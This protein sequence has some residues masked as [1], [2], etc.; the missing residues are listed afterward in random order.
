MEY[1]V[2]KGTRYFGT[3]NK[4]LADGLR[5]NGFRQ[6]TRVW[7]SRMPGT[8]GQT[9]PMNLNELRLGPAPGTQPGAPGAPGTNPGGVRPGGAANPSGLGAPGSPGSG[10]TNPGGTSPPAGT[11]TPGTGTPP[12][13]PGR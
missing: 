8:A 11:T 12:P 4:T 9:G 10:V 1:R 2:G 5:Y 13:A 6:G 7:Y 3:D